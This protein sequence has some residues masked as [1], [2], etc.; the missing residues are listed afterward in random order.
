MLAGYGRK[1]LFRRNPEKTGVGASSLAVWAGLCRLLLG[2]GLIA[3]FS[4]ALFA[5]SMYVGL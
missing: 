5:E 3:L 1:A 2:F 4:A